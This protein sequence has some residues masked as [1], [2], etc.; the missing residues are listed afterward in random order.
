LALA[1]SHPLIARAAL[2]L[3]LGLLIADARAGGQPADYVAGEALVI[4]TTSTSAPAA[5]AATARHHL[6]A[7]RS[8]PAI[9]RERRRQHC[10]VRSSSQSTAELIAELQLDPTVELAEPNYLR[11]VSS[12]PTPNDPSF[13]NLWA[14]HNTGQTVNGTTGT[15][16]A[17]IHFLDAWGLAKPNPPEVVVAVI[18]TGID[19]GHP[20]LAANLWTNHGEIAGDGLDNDGNGYVDDIHGYDF[21]GHVANPSDA[22]LHGT[23]V[24]GIIAAVANNGMGVVGTAF[25]AHIMVLKVSSDGSTID[26]ASELAALNYAVLMKNRGVNIVA[27][28]ASFGGPSFSTSE[29]SAIQATGNAGIVFCAAAGNDSA[30]NTLAQTYPANY[31]LSNMLVVAASDSTDKLAAFSNFGSNVDLAAPGSNILS[32]IPTWQGTSTSTVTRAATSYAASP[33]TYAGLSAGITGKLYHCGYGGSGE[34][35][36][37][38]AGNIALIE[39]GPSSNALTFAAKVTNAMQAGAVAAIIYNNT[40]GAITG[41]LGTPTPTAIAGTWI[42][43]VAISLTDGQALEAAALPTSVS[44]SN[45]VNPAT[46]Y[47]YLDG[48]SMATPYVSAA[49]AFAASN[50]PNESASQRVARIVASVTPVAALTG[51]VASGGRLNLARVVDSDANGLPDWWELAYFGHLGVNPAA[52]ADGDGFT[53]LEEYLIGTQPNNPSSKLAIGQIAVLPNGANKDYQISFATGYG[54]TYRVEFSDSLAAGGWLP[55]GSDLSG[56]G[57]PATATDAAAV[58]L[59]P[60]RFYRL[61]IIAP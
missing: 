40:T 41:T 5:A 55:L 28:N 38:L 58:S 51:K 7:V 18:D 19:L 35:P 23:H 47:T 10:H 36:A 57:S 61:C 11:H 22:G 60:Q 32:T 15:S 17:D 59:H 53:N 3:S 25:H 31:R 16:G 45:I 12:I 52:D 49:V 9:S 21:V 34:F 13:T 26:T 54:V 24:S 27:I 42:P 37:A 2:A 33:F 30:D 14:L 20:D 56:T 46:I 1:A 8:F 48:T 29:S 43:A 44:M 50:F 4:F 6:E 39:R